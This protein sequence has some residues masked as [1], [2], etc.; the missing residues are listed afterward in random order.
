MVPVRLIGKNIV[1]EIGLIDSGACYCVVHQ[2]IAELL[3]AELG[4]EKHLYGLGSKKH[5][6]GYTAEIEIDVG[7]FAEKVEVACISDEHY[8]TK[9]P[10]VII[11]RSFINK[12][13]VILDG[14]KICIE[15]KEKLNEILGKK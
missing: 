14:E 15:N 11:G 12:Y 13:A 9:A 2:K 7:G 3:G 5:I 8:P 1:K 6:I 4:G 10:E